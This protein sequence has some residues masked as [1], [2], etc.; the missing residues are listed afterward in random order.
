MSLRLLPLLAFL[1]TCL[2]L[3]CAS[4]PAP[5]S[6]RSPAH[7]VAVPTV[8]L[9]FQQQQVKEILE[10]LAACSGQKV[11]LAD[12]ISGTLSVD[13]KN[14][15]WDQA[16]EALVLAAG[17]HATRRDDAV[18]VSS[19]PQPGRVAFVA[20]RTEAPEPPTQASR[21]PPD[22]DQRIDVDVE[23]MDLADLMEEI[24]T[25]VGVEI[26][27]GSNTREFVTV[28]LRDI[29]W[30]EAVEV[31]AK[32]TGCQVV[33]HSG[34]LLLGWPAE[35]TISFQEAEVRT[36]LQ[37]LSAYS[38][39]NIVVTPDARST[40]S[41]RLYFDF[42]GASVT[43]LF[44]AIGAIAKTA[45]LSAELKHRIVVVSKSRLGWGQPIALPSNLPPA[46]ST[47]IPPPTHLRARGAKAT[48]WFRLLAMYTG[49]QTV[50]ATDRAGRIAAS[51]E[52]VDCLDALRKT[53]QASGWRVAERGR[54]LLISP[55]KT[56]KAKP[57]SAHLGKRTLTLSGGGRRVSL[58]VQALVVASPDDDRQK[59]SVI[60][61]GTVYFEH[62]HLLAQGAKHEDEGEELPIE[63]LQIR[64]DEIRLKD[65]DMGL[66]VVIRLP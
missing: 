55:G 42:L 52:N 34:G 24:G 1:S 4:D 19:A 18:V 40:A 60:I 44:Q 27:V 58:V 41:V 66:V 32:M 17:L 3:G 38:G 33:P 50:I 37:L 56:V 64:A 30:R 2:T 5:E 31:I 62:D 57:N 59:S 7:P 23:D 65:T 13:L 10:L 21:P 11:R 48:D 46:T 61:G 51:F 28:S 22:S 39:H 47:S 8:T 53:A 35:M 15:P 6:E 25:E 29:P 12:D 43:P 26:R 45:G 49:R 54:Y 9:Q 20:A 36:I 16:L 63:V 14:V